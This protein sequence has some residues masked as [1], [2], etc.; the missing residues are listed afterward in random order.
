MTT[1]E[2]LQTPKQNGPLRD[3]RLWVSITST[4]ARIADLA[5]RLFGWHL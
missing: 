4:A 2:Q 1:S 3:A 5:A